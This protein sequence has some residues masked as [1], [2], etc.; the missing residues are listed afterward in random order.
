MNHLF[1]AND[2]CLMAP[3][4]IVL[5]GLI[6][7]CYQY[8]VEIDLNFK[9]TKSYCV[10]FTPK[11]YKLALPSLHIN[12]LPISYIHSIKYLGYV[13]SCDNSDDAEMLKQMRLQYCRSKRLIRMFK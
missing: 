2:I 4:A 1:Y 6:G 11:L 5:H 12:N 10:A 3:C 8:S 13:F 9:A 7:L